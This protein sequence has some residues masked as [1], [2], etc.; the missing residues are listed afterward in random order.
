MTNDKYKCHL[1]YTSKTAIQNKITDCVFVFPLNSP[2]TSKP[3]KYR[4]FNFLKRYIADVD[5]INVQE[6]QE[7]EYEGFGWY[8]TIPMI[9]GIQ[10]YDVT[11]VD[12]SDDLIKEIKE[13]QL[14]ME[15]RPELR[16]K[17]DNALLKLH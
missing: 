4:D 14:M 2:E 13:I 10:I 11:G 9:G 12:F 16:R 3:D 5:K 6:I 17:V 15:K 1:L 8:C 7:R